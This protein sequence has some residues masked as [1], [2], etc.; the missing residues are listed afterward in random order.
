MRDSAYRPDQHYEFGI[1]VDQFSEISHQTSNAL[2]DTAYINHSAPLAPQIEK[3]NQKQ[4]GI[5]KPIAPMRSLGLA[6][7]SDVV[8]SNSVR[9]AL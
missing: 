8:R 7:L 2:H 6:V 5:S 9:I 4:Q 3:P 1:L